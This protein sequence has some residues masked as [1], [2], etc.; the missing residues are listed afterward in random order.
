MLKPLIVNLFGG[1]GAGKSTTRAG[2]FN[3]LKLKRDSTASS[4]IAGHVLWALEYDEGM[5][6][7]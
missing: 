1:S 7:G 4:I 6:Y 2:V 3:L 5:C